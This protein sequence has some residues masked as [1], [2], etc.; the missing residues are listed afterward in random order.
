MRWG[1]DNLFHLLGVS[2]FTP[3]SDLALLCEELES[4]SAL[5]GT[6]QP[7]TPRLLA[8]FRYLLDNRSEL[9]TERLCAKLVQHV[10]QLEAGGADDLRFTSVALDH[11][12]A[13]DDMLAWL[14]IAQNP[15]FDGGAMLQALN[16]VHQVFEDEPFWH[17][18]SLLCAPVHDERETHVILN[19]SNHRDEIILDPLIRGI[20]SEYLSQEEATALVQA[21][22]SSDLY[23]SERD[24]LADWI[25][26]Y[27]REEASD[28]L[29]ELE[30]EVSVLA[31]AKQQDALTEDSFTVVLNLLRRKWLPILKVP[32]AIDP[33][34]INRRE[35]TRISQSL[36]RLGLLA[37]E[38]FQDPTVSVAI[39]MKAREFS[40]HHEAGH[41]LSQQIQQMR[42]HQAIGVSAQL[43]ERRDLRGCVVCLELAA[44]LAIDEDDR[45]TAERQIPRLQRLLQRG[46]STTPQDEVAQRTADVEAYLQELTSQVLAPQG[47]GRLIVTRGDPT[48]RPPFIDAPGERRS[49][50]ERM[51]IRPIVVGGAG[52]LY[53]ML[54]LAGSFLWNQFH[55]TPPT[56]A[57]GPPTPSVVPTIEDPFVTSPKTTPTGVSTTAVSAIPNSPT[58]MVAATDTPAPVQGQAPSTV[59]DFAGPVET[60]YDENGVIAISGDGQLKIVYGNRTDDPVDA[61]VLTVCSDDSS[62]KKEIIVNVLGSSGD[63]LIAVFVRIPED[64]DSWI[65]LV[66]ENRET[67]S[68]DRISKLSRGK[69]FPWVVPKSYSKQKIGTINTVSV[70][71]DE[72][73]PSLR[74]DGVDVSQSV[75]MPVMAGTINMEVGA[76]SKRPYTLVISR[77][78]VH[79]SP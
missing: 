67:W 32:A 4:G 6:N 72:G 34:R 21:I 46:G 12:G 52:V 22:R 74:L 41:A 18:F 57:Q 66:D 10:P 14:E 2:P 5:P 59:L 8:T 63:G 56:D 3:T 42:F 61:P 70:S 25:T 23:P 28:A 38:R 24:R 76:R 78:V 20:D 27:R 13:H 43:Y 30:V 64:Q 33:E 54:V 1:S 17:C 19:M 26:M 73:R 7:P 29:E 47:V 39:L 45:M 62:A 31:L 40:Q 53:L 37:F 75:T 58:P 68:L 11:F 48:T 35:A 79:A 60:I 55:A 71:I 9:R 77:V 69:P 36:Q 44:E 49:L 15:P 65:F 16:L 50:A 51:H